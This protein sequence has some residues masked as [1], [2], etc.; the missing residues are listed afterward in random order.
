[1]TETESKWIERLSKLV[2]GAEF[3]SPNDLR[4]PAKGLWVVLG[5]TSEMTTS[6]VSIE[7]AAMVFLANVCKDAE[8][9]AALGRPVT[10]RPPP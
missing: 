4:N 9:R 1:M 10:K 7:H 5:P 3:Y 2:R 8:A 6:D